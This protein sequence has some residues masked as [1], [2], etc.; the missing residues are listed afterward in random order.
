M[1]TIEGSG[2]TRRGLFD[3]AVFPGRAQREP[4]TTFFQEETRRLIL[5]AALSLDSGLAF[6]A[7]ERREM[8]DQPADAA[9]GY[10]MSAAAS[11]NFG[12]AE[13]PIHSK[14]T[15]SVVTISTP[16]CSMR[17]TATSTLSGRRD[18]IASRTT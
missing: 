12:C 16:C 18:E 8:G 7:P 14:I 2:A 15:I 6:G 11:R 10:L 5:P 3:L 1:W 13:L 4:V 9:A 17:R